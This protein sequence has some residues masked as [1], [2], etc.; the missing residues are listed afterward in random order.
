MMILLISS[1]IW[2]LREMRGNLEFGWT[3]RSMRIISQEEIAS[4]SVGR[5]KGKKKTTAGETGQ[6]CV[7]RGENGMRWGAGGTG[8]RRRRKEG[9]K[10]KKGNAGKSKRRG[11]RKDDGAKMAGK[12]HQR[13]RRVDDFVTND[14]FRR[15]PWRPAPPEGSTPDF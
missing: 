4:V 8:S 5:G 15:R 12:S 3:Y 2:V 13:P 7:A 6:R 1:Q 14:L 11:A 10:A 9:R